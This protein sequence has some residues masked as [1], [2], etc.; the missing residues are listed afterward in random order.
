MRLAPSPDT[1]QPEASSSKK[2][3]HLISSKSLYKEIAKKYTIVIL[4]AWKVINDFQE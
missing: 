4:V 1:K 2:A 3:L